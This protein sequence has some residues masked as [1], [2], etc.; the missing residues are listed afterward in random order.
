MTGFINSRG[1]TVRQGNSFTIIMRFKLPDGDLNISGLAL[2]MCVRDDNDKIILNKSGAVSDA[3]HG[4][5][6]IELT[7][8]DTNLPLGQYKTDIKAT[9]ADGQVHT[10]Y[11]Q[12]INA[13]AYFNVTEEVSK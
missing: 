12:N 1:I 10:V 5:A 8:Q 13:V 3:A 2:Q 11:P 9:F 7:P 6:V 4:T